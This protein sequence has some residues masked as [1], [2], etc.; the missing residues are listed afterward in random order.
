MNFHEQFEELSKLKVSKADTL[1]DILF[2]IGQKLCICL[3]IERVNVWIFKKSPD[4]IECLGNYTQ[5]KNLFT[6]GQI[7][8]E[9]QIPSYFSHLQSDRTIKIQN[10]NSNEISKELKDSY[11]KEFK[12]QSIMDIP[13][14]IGGKLAGVLCFE[15]CKKER[16]WT[17]EEINFALAVSQIVSLSIEN[18]KR[19]RYEKR[20]EKALEEKDI[21]LV[22]MHHRLKNNLTML[23][24]LLRIQSRSIT[25]PSALSIIENF[26]TQI[27]SISKLH[28]QLYSSKNYIRVN[29]NSYFQ[30]LLENFQTSSQK[31]EIITDFEDVEVS[32]EKA[33]S[34]GLI[35]NE[36][37]NN[38]IKYA[39]PESGEL[40]INF[41]LSRNVL[42]ENSRKTTI[43]VSDNGLGFDL[44]A[45]KLESFGLSLIYDL[46]GQINAKINF[47]SSKNGTSYTINF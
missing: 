43:F 37:L 31:I 7:L 32:S 2:R 28:E 27:L 25:D 33:V 17:D 22:E 1:D 45:E 12:I 42:S 29:L 24:S 13:I 40:I 44:T 5:E 36:I 47:E 11:C 46:S 39:R 26:E 20:L 34:I 8:L 6:K 4:R 30:E 35:I 10:V 18:Q 16:I 41:V 23:N 38:S 9:T 14:R 15:D 19:K 21:L 3:E